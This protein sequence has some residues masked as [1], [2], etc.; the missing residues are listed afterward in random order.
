MKK[1]ILAS[2]SP[3][4]REILSKYNISIEIISSDINE[5]VLDDEDPIQVAMSLAFQ[6]GYDVASKHEGDIV[7]AADTIVYKEKILGKPKNSIE[8]FEMLK[9]LSGEIHQVITG[10]AI[11]SKHNKIIDYEIS[12]VKFKKLSTK[13]IEKYIDTGEYKDKA[14][15]YGIQGYGELLVDWIEGSYSNIVGLPVSKIDD[16]LE[17]YYNINLL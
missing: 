7:L 10:I 13:K 17:N 8:A 16:I 2:S 15:A 5:R 11:I 4:R 6:K 12:H 1:I 9:V 3:R 14:G